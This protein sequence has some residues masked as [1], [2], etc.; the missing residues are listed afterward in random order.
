[1]KT[2]TC[3][4]TVLAYVTFFL[5]YFAVGAP[6]DL[7]LNFNGTGIVSTVV[8]SNDAASS[9]AVQSDGKIVVAGS[10]SNASGHDEFAVVRYNTNGTLDTSFNGSGKV[11][12]AVGGNSDHALAVALQSDGKIV[13]VGDSTI[14]GQLDFAIVRYNVNGSLDT[15][16]NG[17][18]KATTDFDIGND[19][20]KSVAVQADGKIVV[21]G[22]AHAGGTHVFG[23]VRYTASGF[24]DSSFNSTGK[25]TTS[26][27]GEEDEAN[28]IALQTDG[29]IVVVGSSS[30][31][32]TRD[33]AI[34]RYNANGSLDSTFS[35]TGK[36]ILAFGST[37]SIARSVAVQS[38]GKIVAVGDSNY[39]AFALV[40]LNGS[41]TMDTTF[42]GSGKVTTQNAGYG[43]SVVLQS[44]GKILVAGSPNFTLA[45]Y[46]SDGSLNT[47]FGNAGMVTTIFG[48]SDSWGA[49]VAV[50]NDGRIVVAGYSYIYRNNPEGF[51]P[52]FVVLRY[53]GGI[54]PQ[55][56]AVEQPTGVDLSDG[57]ASVPFGAVLTGGT[58]T[59]VF[60]IK[61]TGDT[62]LTGLGIT[63]DGT[64]ANDFD[65]VA[66]PTAPLI[67]N[68]STTFTV[69]FAPTAA[70]LKN[71]ALHIASNDSDENPFDIALTGRGLDPNADDDGDGVTNLAE[72]NLASLGFD[73]LVDNTGLRTALHNNALGLGLF[74]ASDVQ[75]LALGSPLLAKDPN[76]HFHLILSVEKSPN[77]T[78]WTT[79][80]GFTP[81]YNPATGH[82]DLDFGPEASNAQFYKVLGTKP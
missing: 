30:G 57:T 4:L 28:G 26:F 47:T 3:V 10:S 79:L 54:V 80:T 53:S 5:N 55:E 6:G 7:D 16:F 82:I 48:D 68:G 39:S 34:A 81:T 27:R 78:T 51:L 23:L 56:I 11:T 1:M 75:T 19:L 2:N 29:K 65:L 49:G 63:F 38:D 67:G 64:N 8:G 46:N 66:S 70:G 35:G 17:T 76:G 32:G 20:G 36:V 72:V 12:T 61:N 77:L 60:T 43:N 18:G 21:A 42:N 50:Q 40:R 14:G 62:S 74:R 13:V 45:R 22:W 15:S 24:L 73:P 59:R 69:R 44:D 31:G 52:G 37:E 33:F 41:G 25:V 9:V 58:A 71:A